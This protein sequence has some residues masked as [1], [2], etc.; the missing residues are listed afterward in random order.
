MV[1]LYWIADTKMQELGM[2]PDHDAALALHKK[3]LVL[4]NV[5][6]GPNLPANVKTAM[7]LQGRPGGIPRAPMTPTS[8][9]QERAIRLALGD[10]GLR[11]EQGAFAGQN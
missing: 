1:G 9:A 7:R 11:N 3:L 8:E 2:V 10:A 5:L 4:W 6:E